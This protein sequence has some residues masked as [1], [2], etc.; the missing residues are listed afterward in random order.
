MTI[1]CWDGKTLAADKRMTAG[2]QVASVTKIRRLSKGRLAGMAG[3]VPDGFA[4]MDWLNGRMDPTKFT[5]SG[6]NCETEIMV[7]DKGSILI[8]GTGIG[9]V[10]LSIEEPFFAIGSGAPY[11]LGALYCGKSARQAVEIACKFD[12][13]CGNGVDVLTL[14]PVPTPK[15]RAR[16]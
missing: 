3:V 14:E 10:P 11:A 6:D 1:I 16:R 8:Y 2:T 12:A 4:L 15:K 9:L 13:A 7:I 5:L